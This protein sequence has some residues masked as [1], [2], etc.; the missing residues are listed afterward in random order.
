MLF[1]RCAEQWLIGPEAPTRCRR[2][3]IPH[4]RWAFEKPITERPRHVQAAT[5][6]A[7][8]VYNEVICGL[9]RFKGVIDDV[10]NAQAGKPASTPEV[11]AAI[12][13]ALPKR[14]GT[15]W[16][17]EGLLPTNGVCGRPPRL[18][19]SFFARVSGQEVSSDEERLGVSGCGN[20][21]P[22]LRDV[23]SEQAVARAH[24]ALPGHRVGEHIREN[25][26]PIGNRGAIR[27]HEACHRR[28]HPGVKVIE[29]G[30]PALQC[31]DGVGRGT[32]PP[33]MVAA[34]R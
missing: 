24:S 20:T 23:E 30:E 8:Q 18:E 4:R 6:I 1:G 11:P 17:L 19:P 10:F 21:L 26:M 9:E 25:N 34:D 2:A 32:D 31:R 27:Q 28:P 29:G 7:S 15:C 16:R 12:G 22:C 13:E 3:E 33:D 14:G 5:P